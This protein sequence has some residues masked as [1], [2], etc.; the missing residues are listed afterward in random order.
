MN[1]RSN[2][3]GIAGAE[4]LFLLSIL[5]IIVSIAVPAVITVLNYQKTKQT[6]S[7]VKQLLIASQQLNKEYRVWPSYKSPIRGD[8]RYGEENPNR[9]VMNILLAVEGEGNVS[10][11]A[12]PMRMEFISMAGSSTAALMFSPSGDVLDLWGS[13]YQFV[14]DTN[15]DNICVDPE[16]DHEFVLGTGVIIWSL[17]PDRKS[18]TKDDICTW[19]R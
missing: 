5:L 3:S 7:Q 18:G 16:V 14:F 6:Y 15:Y 19:Q 9:Y 4:V 13:P 8:V 17:G 10:H 2:K 11:L 1:E 12:N